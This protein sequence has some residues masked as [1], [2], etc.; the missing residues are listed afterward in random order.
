MPTLY[1]K[2]IQQI[3][4]EKGYQFK[5]LDSFSEIL[6]QIS[7]PT[8]QIL[9]SSK[10]YPL[11]T[12]SAM[13]IANDK[14]LTALVLKNAGINIPEGDYFFISPER[15]QA[16]PN[17]KELLDAI[18]YA[19]FLQYPVFIKPIN[20]LSGHFALLINNEAD[21]L[22]ALQRMAQKYYATIIQKPL[23]QVEQRIFV[24]DNKV[25]FAYAKQRAMIVGDGI[26]SIKTLM[27]PFIENQ[28]Y[29]INS[30][31]IQNSLSTKGYSYTTILGMQ[32]QF[33]LSSNANPNSGGIISEIHT[34][35]SKECEAWAI[36]IAQAMGLDI[37]GID[38]FAPQG[39]TDNPSKFTVIEV[40]ANPSLKTMWHLGYQELI[41]S[42]WEDILQKSFQ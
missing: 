13:K 16:R 7:T 39:L 1:F 36:N 23:F 3:C 31:Y 20:G 22:L 17:G 30:E 29:I 19:K 15:R 26:N 6:A 14:A 35:V 10:N 2:I 34:S 42:I 40:N 11:N 27:V 25:R 9:I 37:C 8:R 12:A 24:L 28:Q 4:I 5:N 41:K 21:L 32:E 18:N 38:F 33:F